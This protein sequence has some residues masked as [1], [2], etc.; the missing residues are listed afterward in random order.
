MLIFATDVGYQVGNLAS[1]STDPILALWKKQSAKQAEPPVGPEKRH[2][3][4][5]FLVS[6]DTPPIFPFY[7]TTSG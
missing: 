1:G 3:L 6:W 5:Y 7:V 2:S 4:I